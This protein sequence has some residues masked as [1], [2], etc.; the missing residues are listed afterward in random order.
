MSND[1]DYDQSKIGCQI[2]TLLI[3]RIP[4]Y[5]TFSSPDQSSKVSHSA[6]QGQTGSYKIKKIHTKSYIV[7][8]IDTESYQSGKKFCRVPGA[9][10]DDRPVPE[11]YISKRPLFQQFRVKEIQ[12]LGV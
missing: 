9:Q 11:S 10:I 2:L 12:F 4:G 7:T 1:W 5:N 3:S 6:V 8:Q